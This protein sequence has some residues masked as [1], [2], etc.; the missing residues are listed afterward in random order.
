MT[1]F[2]YDMTDQR[3]NLFKQVSSLRAI[4]GLLVIRP[5]DSYEVKMAWI[6]ALK[7]EGPT[8]LI[9][10]RQPLPELNHSGQIEDV[11]KGAYIVKHEETDSVEYLLLAY[12]IQK[13]SA[14]T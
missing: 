8:A 6:A 7:Y 3:I 4:P 13:N 1:L 10:S 12:W 9:L 5:A 11:L 14:S 2:F